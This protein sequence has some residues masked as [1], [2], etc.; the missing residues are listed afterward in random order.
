MQQQLL[1]IE[2][3]HQKPVGLPDSKQIR[4]YGLPLSAQD[5]FEDEMSAKLWGNLNKEMSWD[6]ALSDNSRAV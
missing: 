3:V 4:W 5:P 2:N 1:D 6:Y